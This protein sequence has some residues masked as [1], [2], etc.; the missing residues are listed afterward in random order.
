MLRKIKKR[1]EKMKREMLITSA[2]FMIFLVV[3]IPICSADAYAQKSESINIKSIYGKDKIEKIRRA[4]DD[5]ITVVAEVWASS[6]INAGDVKFIP[7]GG[8]GVSF[9]TCN[10][11]NPPYNYNCTY[12]SSTGTL[13]PGIYPFKACIG[14]GPRCEQS[15]AQSEYYVDGVPP[16]I[17][18]FDINP[19]K[20]NGKNLTLTYKVE[21]RVCSTQS[22][23][24]KC[25]GI[26]KI[27]IIDSFDN[28]KV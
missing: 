13:S 24:G 12:I 11:I 3:T 5:F 6:A 21:D 4:Q 9:T 16:K 18:S 14:I 7:T 2:M 27:E 1:N 15:K 10:I 26:S 23:A 25:S 22:C 28:N 19:K 17:V 8:V 20:T